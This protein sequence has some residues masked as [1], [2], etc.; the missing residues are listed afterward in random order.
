MQNIMVLDNSYQILFQ[1]NQICA[2]IRN[3]WI[4]LVNGNLS[5]ICVVI[6]AFDIC[7]TLYFVLSEC[8]KQSR[9]FSL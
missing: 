6:M 2:P 8:S 5:S 3:S 1:N 4:F 7:F 9:V